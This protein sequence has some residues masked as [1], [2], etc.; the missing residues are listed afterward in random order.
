MSRARPFSGGYGQELAELMRQATRMYL[1]LIPVLVPPFVVTFIVLR[2]LLLIVLA[3]EDLSP[4]ALLLTGALIQAVIPAF[5]GSLLLSAAIPVVAGEAGRL[6]EAWDGLAERRRDIYRA[7][8]WSAILALF[9]TVTLGPVGIII[10]PMLLGPPLLLHEIVLKR[11][12]VHL[13][14]E[15]TREMLGA[16]SR[17]LVYLLAIPAILGIVLTTFL[18]AFGVLSGDIP[19]V[20][21]GVLYFAVQGA[22]V[23]AAIPFVAAIGL[24]LYEEMASNLGGD[25]E[26]R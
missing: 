19:G 22:L 20:I 23:G 26:A 15:R 12:G 18:R 4:V 13:A 25:D 9:A 5:L 11:H 24:L 7:A 1:A 8:R 6:R 14:W 17:H 3:I 10:Q 2:E 16:D 21:R